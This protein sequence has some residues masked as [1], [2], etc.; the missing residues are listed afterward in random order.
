MTHMEY[1]KALAMEKRMRVRVK[2]CIAQ[3]SNAVR[4]EAEVGDVVLLARGDH[5][6]FEAKI[7]AVRSEDMVVVAVLDGENEI[8]REIAV[9]DIHGLLVCN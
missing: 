7:N 1:A 8:E 9:S 4:Y 2:Q 5:S 6:H 3:H